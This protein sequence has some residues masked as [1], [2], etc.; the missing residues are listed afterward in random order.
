[1]KHRCLFTSILLFGIAATAGCTVYQTGPPPGT[2]PP[3]PPAPPAVVIQE[4]QYLYLMPA[5]GVYFIPGVTF[6]IL[7]YNGLWY[8][9]VRGTWYWGHSYRGPWNYII[10]GRVPGVLRK[11][12]PDYR[13]QY[14]LDRYR[15]PYGHWKQRWNEPPPKS[16]YKPPGYLYKVPH[17]GAY[18]YPRTSDQIYFRKD[19]WYKR[20][21]G[22]WYW[23]WSYNGPWAYMKMDQVPRQ[24]R[25][26]P[27]Q[28]YDKYEKVPWNKGWKKWGR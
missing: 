10:I 8:Y 11:L 20:Y 9:N 12:P 24:M 21:K 6:D 17:T 2:P 19:R 13:R 22:L 27:Y 16:N 1:M 28:G 4:P 5:S 15:V 23:S 25:N 3:A 26:M 18:A 7:Y 14:G